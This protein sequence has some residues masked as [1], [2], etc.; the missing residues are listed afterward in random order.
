MAGR[1]RFWLNPVKLYDLSCQA[2][3]AG[4]KSLVPL[5]L[6]TYGSVGEGGFGFRQ[7]CFDRCRLYAR[8]P[9]ELGG[10]STQ[11]FIRVGLI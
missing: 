7:C 1:C 11:G 5:V 4:G 10:A 2:V 6:L 3:M 8:T 9:G